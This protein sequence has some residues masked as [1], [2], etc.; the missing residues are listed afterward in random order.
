MV[1]EGLYD[2]VQIYFQ[3][4]QGPPQFDSCQLL[5]FSY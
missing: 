3:D 4:L 1:P 5:C 2:K